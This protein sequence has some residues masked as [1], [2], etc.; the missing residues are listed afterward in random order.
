MSR[1]TEASAPALA[2]LFQE[3]NL[4]DAERQ[5][6][7]EQGFVHRKSRGRRGAVFFLRFRLN[8]KQMARY[9]GTDAERARTIQLALES[10][11][12][13]H[14]LRRRLR[15]RIRE[16]RTL[17]ATVKAQIAQYA[18]ARGDGCFHRRTLRQPRARRSTAPASK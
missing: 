5:A 3:L 9:L 14:A 13:P 10:W 16:M 4:T 2:T 7:R 15:K 6:V 18:V 11:Q 8:G 12:R 17:L 1:Q